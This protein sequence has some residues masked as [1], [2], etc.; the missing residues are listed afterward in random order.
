ML[1]IHALYLNNVSGI[2]AGTMPIDSIREIDSLARVNPDYE[3]PRSEEEMQFVKDFEEA[4]KY[5]L[6][7]LDPNPVP[8]DGVFFYKPVN[9]VISSRYQTDIHHYGVDLVA[10]PKESVLA[11][12]PFRCGF[13]G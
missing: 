9:G 10:A 11:H 2:L 5:N 7:V 12:P 3:I 13:G 6:T 8:T 4:E 1:Q